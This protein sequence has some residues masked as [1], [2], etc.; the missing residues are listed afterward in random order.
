[1]HCGKLSGWTAIL[2]EGGDFSNPISL[3]LKDVP[4]NRR[5][6]GEGM[7]VRSGPASSMYVWRASGFPLVERQKGLCSGYWSHLETQE[8]YKEFWFQIWPS[9]LFLEIFWEGSTPLPVFLMG[10]FP[11]CLCR[12]LA[13]PALPATVFRTSGGFHSSPRPPRLGIAPFKEEMTPALRG[14][15]VESLEPAREP[16]SGILSLDRDG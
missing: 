2:L 1:M 7:G 6:L 15:W 9:C 5:L 12:I 14:H 10:Y 11:W 4:G 13:G 3:K 8:G 16:F